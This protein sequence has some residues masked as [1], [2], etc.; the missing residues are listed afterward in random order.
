M[1]KIK[2]ASTYFNFDWV[3]EKPTTLTWGL[4]N[5]K[6]LFYFLEVIITSVK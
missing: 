2:I 6:H 1:K 5:L 4:E 3:W